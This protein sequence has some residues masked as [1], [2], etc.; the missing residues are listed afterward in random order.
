MAGKLIDRRLMRVLMLNHNVAWGGG[1]FNR[2]YNYG[3]EL[4]ALGH[5]ITL[6]SISPARRFTCR[7]E[8]RDGI[9]VV[10]TPDLLWGVMR[11]GWD[12]WDTVW[13]MGWLRG[14]SFDLVHA[15]DCRPAVILPALYA[16]RRTG[17]PLVI[18]W[19]DWWG[20]GGTIQERSGWFV[21]TFFGP[22]ET[23]FEEAFRARADG[24]TV[25]SR[26]LY[27]RAAGLGVP[28]ESMILLPQGSDVGS[29]YPCDKAAAREELGLPPDVHIVGHLGVLLRN[30][31]V[32]LFSSM[33]LVQQKSP[34]CRLLL[35]GNH[36]QRVDASLPVG[37][38]II[39]T[40]FVS[41]EKLVKYLAAC[42]VLVLPLLDTI[43]G[44]GRWPS[45]IG[46]YLA[47]GR[48]VV[49]TDVGDASVLLREHEAGLVTGDNPTALSEGIL[50]LLGDVPLREKLGSRARSVAEGVLAWP[51]LADRIE[52]FYLQYTNA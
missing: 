27:D 47:A 3:R 21:R 32:L 42:D 19:A 31:A 10:E 8:T 28:E 20:R 7:Y 44:R 45:K 16:K 17:R 26:A 36:K 43:A 46:D 40:G 9:N 34:G 6:L 35:V 29:V 30:D 4:A 15:F 11:T 18:D 25:I 50:S 14:R 41:G 52:K 22:V 23:F 2:C 13:R 48:P 38:A 33:E 12:L 51:L 39:E 49:S 1:T 5:E 37:G 24:T